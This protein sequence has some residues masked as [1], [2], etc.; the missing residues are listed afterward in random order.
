MQINPDLFVVSFVEQ[1]A[2]T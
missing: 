1:I 2:T